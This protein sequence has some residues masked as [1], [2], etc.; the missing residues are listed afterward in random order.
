MTMSHPWGVALGPGSQT[1]IELPRWH[2]DWGPAEHRGLDDSPWGI[3]RRPLVLRRFVCAP[4]GR[5]GRPKVWNPADRQAEGVHVVPALLF[6]RHP[7]QRLDQ[8]LLAGAEEELA[9]LD[10][11]GDG[12]RA[13]E[14]VGLGN[15]QLDGWQMDP[16]EAGLT[17]GD[18]LQ[19]GLPCDLL[20]PEFPWS[21]LV[22]QE[23]NLPDALVG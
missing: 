17:L 2:A 11:G 5:S 20:Y 4:H 15:D 9:G 13:T 18:V 1:Q 21:E 22:H 14:L 8:V 12:E 3:T 23:E 16:L 7:K 10:Q 6:L 19:R